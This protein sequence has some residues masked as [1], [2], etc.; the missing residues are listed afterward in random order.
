[1]CLE[2]VLAPLNQGMGVPNQN[3]IQINLGRIEPFAM[4]GSGWHQ[5]PDPAPQNSH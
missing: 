5:E 4:I 2:R 3:D 1:V